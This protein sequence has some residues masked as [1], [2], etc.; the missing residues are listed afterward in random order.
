MP[1]NSRA[2]VATYYLFGGGSYCLVTSPSSRH[3]EP[4]KA[5][6]SL[7][8]DCVVSCT[9][10]KVLCFINEFKYQCRFHPLQSLSLLF[11]PISR[12]FTRT[13]SCNAHPPDLYTFPSA[14]F[15]QVQENN[16]T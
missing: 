5:E 15:F 3:E 6:H 1:I 16:V 11:H 10:Y 4:H 14:Y 8:N 12:I 2:K 9:L 13:A 7:S